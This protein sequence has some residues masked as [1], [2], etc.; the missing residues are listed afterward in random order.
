MRLVKRGFAMT[1]ALLLMV[2]AQPMAA[3][4]SSPKILEEK[5]IAE[6]VNAGKKATPSNAKRAVT[7]PE[8]EI[9]FNTGN[10]V[11]S[12]VSKEDFFEHEFGDAFFEEDGSYTINIPEPNPFFPYEVE[13][14]YD[15]KETRKWFMSPDDCIEI[16]GHLFYVSAYFD[17]TVVTQMSLNVG[18]DTVIAYP[19]KKKFIDEETEEAEPMSLLP[20]ERRNLN[21]DLSAYTPAELTMVSVNEIFAGDELADG[22]KVIWTKR[23]EDDYTISLPGDKLNLSCNTSFSGSSSSNV[24]WEMI[25]G[26]D[27][28]LASDNVRYYVDVKVKSSKDWLIPTVY[29]QNSEGNRIKR[30]ILND[31]YSFT[32]YSDYSKDE[33]RLHIT[34]SDENEEWDKNDQ[35]YICLEINNDLFSDTKYDHFKVYEGE[36]NS[37]SEAQS[38]AD[39]TDKLFDVDM[40]QTDAGYTLERYEDTWITMITFDAEGNETGCLPFYLY[41]VRNHRENSIYYDLQLSE[42]E[43]INTNIV[44]YKKTSRKD[45]LYSVTFTLYKG[46]AAN[47]IYF[48]TA[49]YDKEIEES[50]SEIIAAYKGQYSSIQ[51]AEKAGAA[52]IKEELFNSSG[53]GVNYSNGIFFTIFAGENKQNP[54]ET[55]QSFVK[56]EEGSTPKPPN[57]L[58][59][60]TH[61][62]FYGLKDDNE[63]SIDGHVIDSD[64]DSYSENNYI[65]ILVNEDVDL[66]H[67]AP[68]FSLSKTA[69]LYTAGSSTPEISGKSYH[70]FSKGAVQYTVSA[71]NGVNSRNVWLQ[72]I[73][74]GVKNGNLYLNSLADE[75]AN[76]KT[77]NGITYSTREMFLDGRYDY[78]HD[79]LLINT[80]KT[81][82]PSIS[83]ELVSDEVELDKYWTLNGNYEL[84]DISN[85]DTDFSLRYGNLWNL[86]KLRIKPKEGTADGREING[87]LTIKSGE[88]RLI[89]LTLTG[90]VGD[91]SITTKEIPQAVKYVP[92]GTMIQNNNK[93]SWNQV[94]YSL[95]DGKLPKGME[96]KENGELYG[97]PTE[98]GDFTFTVYMENSYDSFSPSEKTF[99]LT[100]VEN[101]DTNVDAATDQG[102]LLTQ[103][104]QNISLNTNSDQTMISEGIYDE[105]V[106]LFL[107]G[108]KLKKDVDYTSE[109]GSTRI[110]IRGETLKA[111][112][113]AGK[114]TLGVEFRT[115]EAKTLKRAAQ[116][117]EVT[118][119]NQNNSSGS[120]GGNSSSSGSSGGGSSSSKRR[121]SDNTKTTATVPRDAKKGYINEQTGIIPGEGEGYSKWQQDEQGR[122]LIYADG[123]TA[124]GYMI[125]LPDGTAA[126]QVLWEQVNGLWYAFGASGYAK[127]GWVYDYQFNCWYCATAE[128]GMYS[129]WY[130]DSQDNYAYYLEPGTGRISVGWKCIDDKWYYFN[131]TSLMPSW[132]FNAV[133]GEWI[134]NNLSNYKPY[135]SMYSNEL[136]PDGYFVGADG[137]WDGQDK[138]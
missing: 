113:T 133:T 5:E 121:K 69:N 136:T 30:E 67:L 134:Y 20:L 41:L 75:K 84:P 123:T 4:K 72:V 55:Y 49:R 81:A 66:T 82:I 129:G 85:G 22:D 65:T 39:I 29:T 87:T 52:D 45:G 57:L 32:N 86:A 42:N 35:A 14:T 114:H 104:I 79:I 103:R 102:Y 8:E 54:E 99:T 7:K 105:F 36:F 62:Y 94:S 126:E 107:D 108:V 125:E 73:K 71:E 27:N 60:N 58:S 13:F 15:G 90:I 18:G 50:S 111:N 11:Y 98:T 93:Y 80:G 101:T 56:I 24:P 53:Y 122:K 132:N 17:G 64:E 112:N 110:T 38:G 34:A 48:L 115:G 76:T 96:L 9:K 119:R 135:G 68:V 91:P 21:V 12:V 40:T 130:R 44:D 51:E 74:A 97:V 77:E 88:N 78:E 33:R 116:N 47:K 120:S 59:S 2:S 43:I 106:D 117:Y 109:S 124:S 3:E 83:V 61:V 128:Y 23:Y 70:D 16:N 100:I 28:Q 127:S 31:K 26:D 6:G 89:V 131:E 95:E 19:E 92:Y 1:M 137:V 63:D 10:H 37:L 46:Y 138:P 25:V 118:T